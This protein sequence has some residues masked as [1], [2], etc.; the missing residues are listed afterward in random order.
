MNRAFS[1]FRKHKYHAN[2]TVVGG[3]RFA[4]QREAKRWGELQLMVRAGVITNLQR[5]V[6]FELKAEGGRVICKYVADFVYARAGRTVVEDAKGFKTDMY[7][8]K[9]KWFEATYPHQIIEV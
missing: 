9:K 2:A 5:Q 7:R 3:I 6:A 4:S 8:L 1:H